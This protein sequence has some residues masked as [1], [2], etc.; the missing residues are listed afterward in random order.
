[1]LVRSLPENRAS[2]AP[3]GLDMALPLF[4]AVRLR[5][6]VCLPQ[7]LPVQVILITT[8]AWAR[9]SLFFEN[10]SPSGGLSNF[11]AISMDKPSLPKLAPD[12]RIF[13]TVGD[14]MLSEFL[15]QQAEAPAS[16]PLLLELSTSGGDADVGRR[17]AEELRLW[18]DQREICFLGKAYVFSAG[19]T[20]MSAFPCSKRFLTRDCE[21]L[22]HERKLKKDLHLDGALRGC[23]SIVN[24]VLAEIDSGQRLQRAGFAKLVEGSA[25][26]ID[27]LERRVFEKDRYL[28]ALEA[29]EAGLIADIL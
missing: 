10:T 7:S 3:G 2:A 26:T 29:R 1:M 6:A 25:W 20:I 5:C 19:I 17:I 11:P 9:P 16:G 28:T 12:I 18:M 21:L 13:G 8:S 4:F 23:R 27:D 22:I 15:R 24:D 14:S